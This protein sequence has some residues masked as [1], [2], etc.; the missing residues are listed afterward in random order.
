MDAP[1]PGFRTT[2]WSLVQR[3]KVDDPG[4]R[5]ALNELCAV[6]WPAVVG[7][8]R[9]SGLGPEDAED[10]AQ[11]LFAR[12]LERRDLVALDSAVG[13]FRS[14]LRTAA[15][16][17]SSN[18]LASERAARRGGDHRVFSIDGTAPDDA[19]LARVERW[20]E[21]AVDETPERTFDRLWAL[22]ALEQAWAR[23]RAEQ[24]LR[25][26]AELFDALRPKLAPGGLA[27]ADSGTSYAE[28]APRFATTEGALKVAVHRWR[29]RLRELL[30]AE[31]RDTLPE[32]DDGVDELGELLEAL[33]SPD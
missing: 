25:G 31:V 12:I 28:L 32:G 6:Y 10:T 9:R 16:H 13:R 26:R 8:L 23:L 33:R 18:T 21:P 14:W 15:R 22:A 24:A 3:A 19:G 4:G 2:R 1:G 11:G 29:Q 20:L 30:V 27:G 17:A 5:A 7:F